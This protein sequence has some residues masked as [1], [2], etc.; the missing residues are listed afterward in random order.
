MLCRTGQSLS[1]NRAR[2]R[3]TGLAPEKTCRSGIAE[4]ALLTGAGFRNFPAS[5]ANCF[6]N[7]TERITDGRLS[8]R[9]KAK[10]MA[11]EKE[12]Q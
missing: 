3:L 2:C 10:K 1:I 5:R 4:P 6:N 9:Q 11:C 12:T 8:G 7:Q